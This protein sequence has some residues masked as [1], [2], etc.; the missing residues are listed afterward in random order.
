MKNGGYERKVG[1]WVGV[2]RL[3]V[4]IEVFWVEVEGH[5]D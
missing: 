5:E 2:E 3:L 4:G 1:M